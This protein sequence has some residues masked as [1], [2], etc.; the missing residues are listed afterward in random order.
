VSD[1]KNFGLR[2]WDLRRAANYG[3]PH[4]NERSL[5]VSAATLSEDHKTVT[6]TVP[7]LK[8][9]WGLELWYSVVGADGRPVDGLYHGSIFKMGE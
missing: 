3:S 4:L 5:S 2:V 7:G 8:P 9:T 6:L 1:L